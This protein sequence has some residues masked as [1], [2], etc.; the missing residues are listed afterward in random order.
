MCR[1]RAFNALWNQQGDVR[2]QLKWGRKLAAAD[3][4]VLGCSPV[5]LIFP[6]DNCTGFGEIKDWDFGQVRV[7]Q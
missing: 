4:W 5:R 6:Y 7:L 1:C 2:V 3:V